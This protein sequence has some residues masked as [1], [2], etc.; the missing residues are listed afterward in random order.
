MVITLSYKMDIMTSSFWCLILGIWGGYCSQI[1]LWGFR[2]P[3]IVLVFCTFIG[4]L[5]AV[6]LIPAIHLLLG[7]AFRLWVIIPYFIVITFVSIIYSSFIGASLFSL[8][9]AHSGSFSTRTCIPVISLFVILTTLLIR[10]FENR[11]I[12]IMRKK[13]LCVNCS[14]DMRGTVSDICSECGWNREDGD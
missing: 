13:E 8:F 4:M 6:A 5:S 11:R 12:A 2:P 14:Y 10:K 3:F 9:P 7:N 1:V